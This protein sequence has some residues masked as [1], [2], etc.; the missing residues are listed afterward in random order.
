MVGALAALLFLAL[1]VVQ[2][3]AH[4]APTPTGTGRQAAAIADCLSTGKV[5]VFVITEDA[6]VLA[7]QCVESPSSGSDALRLAGIR[8]VTNKSGI[9]CTMN[10][11]PAAC[12]KT[13]TGQYWAYYHSS[14]AGQPWTY[15]KQGAEGYHP[16]GG[17]IEGWCYNEPRTKSCTPPTLAV[18]DSAG[19]SF[20]VTSNQP[21]SS[22]SGAPTGTIIVIVVVVVVLVVVG[23]VVARR[24]RTH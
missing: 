1:G 21:A 5:W 3:A 2:P 14:G 19:R 17:T 10:D 15:S 7:N 11:H 9:I 12:P 18:G 8:T 20:P 13:F 22:S 6:E 4:A 24:R 23:V 16:A